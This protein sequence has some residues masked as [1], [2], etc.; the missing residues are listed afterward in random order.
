M[1]P[2]HDVRLAKAVFSRRQSNPRPMTTEP[3]QRRTC[4]H[5]LVEDGMGLRQ[6]MAVLFACCV[7]AAL[8]VGTLLL[9]IKFSN[10]WTVLLRQSIAFL[11]LKETIITKLVVTDGIV[12]QYRLIERV[13][14]VEFQ[15]ECRLQKNS[16]WVL[17]PPRVPCLVSS[18]VTTLTTTLTSRV[19]TIPVF[20][21]F[22]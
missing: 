13:C 22:P 2:A 19:A 15:Q 12:G 11:V 18:C 4:S 6:R 1:Y 17:G 5:I 20:L 8:V 21:S 7:G 3:P 16:E 10:D 14:K 9:W